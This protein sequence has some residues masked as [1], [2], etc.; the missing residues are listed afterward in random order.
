[1]EG[2]TYHVERD[3]DNLRITT[4][5]GDIPPQEE[6][7]IVWYNMESFGKSN[8]LTEFLAGRTVA[9]GDTHELPNEAAQRLLAFGDD[10]VEVERFTL[11][12]REITQS[13]GQHAAFRALVSSRSQGASQMGMQ[14]EGTLVVDAATCR[15]RS[16]DLAGPVGLTETKSNGVETY[17]LSGRGKI[18]VAMRGEFA[19]K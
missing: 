2:K 13:G 15:V 14:V 10:V 3:G 11:T 8:P 12:L 7:E 17:L 4:A 18:Q 6:Y 9:V 5:T 1:V 19:T 16:L